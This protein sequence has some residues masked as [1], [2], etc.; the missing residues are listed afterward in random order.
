[1]IGIAVAVGVAVAIFVGV[2]VFLIRSRYGKVGSGGSSSLG[3]RE[4]E[5]IVMSPFISLP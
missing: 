2:I 5:S 1:M 4:W 3:Q